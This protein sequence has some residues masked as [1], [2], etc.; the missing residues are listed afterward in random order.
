MQRNKTLETWLTH[1]S[2]RLVGSA[3]GVASVLCVAYVA[4]YANFS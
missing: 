3:W 2:R 1:L 4:W